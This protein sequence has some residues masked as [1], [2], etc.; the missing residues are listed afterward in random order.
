MALTICAV[1]D[2]SYLQQLPEC[3]H[4]GKTTNEQIAYL[5]G[6]VAGRKAVI[7]ALN[8]P[9]PKLTFWQRVDKAISLIIKGS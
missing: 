1:C 6:N 7:D 8:G 5:Q 9:L 4:C 2:K 3:R